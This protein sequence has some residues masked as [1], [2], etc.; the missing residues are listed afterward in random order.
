LR[1]VAATFESIDWFGRSSQP[2][3]SFHIFDTC[4]SDIGAGQNDS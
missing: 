2:S 1:S 3:L 4:T